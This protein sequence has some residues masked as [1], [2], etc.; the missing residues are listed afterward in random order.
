MRSMTSINNAQYLRMRRSNV[1][2]DIVRPVASIA[3]LHQRW[4]KNKR[5]KLIP[6]TYENASDTKAEALSPYMI[7]VEYVTESTN[8]DKYVAGSEFKSARKQPVLQYSKLSRNDAVSVAPIIGATI[9]LVDKK[10]DAIDSN[11]DQSFLLQLKR[12]A[13]AAPIFLYRNAYAVTVQITYIAKNAWK[14]V[15]TRI[16]FQGRMRQYS[17]AAGSTYKFWSIKHNKWIAIGAPIVV[18]IIAFAG[19]Q[20]LHTAPRHDTPANSNTYYSKNG[21]E[22]P[23]NNN[24]SNRNTNGGDQASP[25]IPQDTSKPITPLGKSMPGSIGG[26]SSPTSAAPSSAAT[27]WSSSPTPTVSSSPTTNTPSIAA[28]STSTPQPSSSTPAVAAPSAVQPNASAPA[29]STP[30]PN[31]T[32]ALVPNVSVPTIPIRL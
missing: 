29:A 11:K 9:G 25:K 15:K 4:L 23:S 30:P 14:V 18:A 10:V 32:P 1:I 20:A 27:T 21:A 13:F 3:Q 5:R 6:V 2:S 8:K 17:V 28:P 16:A 26:Q 7:P 22:N 31:P 12:V 24:S 19:I